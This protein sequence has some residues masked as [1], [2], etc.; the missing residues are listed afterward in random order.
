[1]VGGNAPSGFI[2]KARNSGAFDIAKHKEWLGAK[3]T[4]G[5]WTLRM[6][7][8]YVDDTTLPLYP[9]CVKRTNSIDDGDNNGN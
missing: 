7:L 9:I 5:K 8:E 3:I 2:T 6:L 1:M 4:E